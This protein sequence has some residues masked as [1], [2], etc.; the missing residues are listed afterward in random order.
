MSNHSNPE[1]R[2]NRVKALRQALNLS[3]QKFA[4]RLAI[5]KS[6]IQNWEEGRHTGLTEKGAKRLVSSLLQTGVTSSVDWLLFGTGSPP[7]LPESLFEKVSQPIVSETLPDGQNIQ[8]ELLLFHQLNKGC[9]DF[10]VADNNMQPLYCQGDIVAGKR[11]F[12]AELNFAVNHDCIV[13][14]ETGETLLRFVTVGLADT[15]NLFQYQHGFEKTMTHQNIRL[16][17]A[18]PIIWIRRLLS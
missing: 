12:A 17:S 14:T 15:Y 16:F 3:R 4:D 18:A 10:L 2:G 13:Q 9:I 1:T 5:K 8:R 11:Y 7:K 6:T